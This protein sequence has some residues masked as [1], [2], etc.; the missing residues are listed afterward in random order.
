MPSSV[1]NSIKLFAAKAS[2]KIK[3]VFSPSGKADSTT[4]PPPTLSVDQV[5]NPLFSG[6]ETTPGNIYHL[7][8]WTLYLYYR[9]RGTRSQ[10]QHG[11]LFKDGQEVNPTQ[12]GQIIQTDLGDLKYYKTP[13][14]MTLLWDMTGWNFAGQ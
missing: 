4:P 6:T 3:S 5:V 11:I 14:E 2:H 7:G 1:W 9:N 8:A 10:G 12:V 13:E